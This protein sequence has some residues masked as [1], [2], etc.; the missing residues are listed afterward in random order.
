MV[1]TPVYLWS[2]NIKKIVEAEEIPFDVWLDLIQLTWMRV[3]NGL[4]DVERVVRNKVRQ[5][6]RENRPNGGAIWKRRRTNDSKQ[7]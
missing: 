3:H 2:L 6:D 5:I 7:S 1:V 4:G